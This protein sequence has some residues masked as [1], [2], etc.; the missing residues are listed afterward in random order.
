VLAL[1]AIAIV[2]SNTLV[3]LL[4]G[5]STARATPLSVLRES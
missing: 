1:V 2:L 3:G 4:V 5:R